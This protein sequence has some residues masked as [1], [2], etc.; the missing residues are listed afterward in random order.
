MNKIKKFIT[1]MHVRLAIIALIAVIGFVMLS[2]PSPT[3]DDNEDPGEDQG[4]KAGASVSVPVLASKTHNSITI[5]PSAFI[6][7]NPGEQTIEYAINGV[8]S[9]PEAGWQGGLKFSGLG[10]NMKYWIF[11]RSKSNVTHNAGKASTGLSVTTGS[12]KEAGAV[13]SIPVLALKTANSITIKAVAAPGN[14]Q[15]VE[16]AKNGT[17][18]APPTGWQD[19]LTFSGLSPST[20]YWIFARSKSNAAYN[21]GKA[22]AGLSV[23]TEPDINPLDTTPPVLSGG[24]INRTSNT[25]ALITFTT[26]EA[27]TA[28]YSQLT[29]GSPAPSSEAVKLA[30][31]IGAVIAGTNIEPVTLEAGVRD[32][33]VVVEDAAGN[34]SSPLKIEAPAYVVMTYNIGDI[35]PGGGIIFYVNPSGFTVEG[36]SGA[37]GAFESYT[38]HYLEAAPS[39]FSTSAQWGAYGTLISGITTFTSSTDPLANKIGNG[40]KDTLTIVAHLGTSETNRAAQLAA[41]ATFGGK[42]DWFLPSLGELNLLYVQKSLTGITTGYFWSSSQSAIYYAWLQDFSNGNRYVGTNDLTF[43]VRSIRAF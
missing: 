35:G 29:S 42:N 6:D 28:Y 36:Y 34:K 43:T 26:D 22:S 1:N 10:S 8:N 25:A 11:A 21:T 9:V 5:K 19:G 14:G 12:S 30:N 31:T 13:V 16:Y 27:G 24:S 2:C 23:T 37:E 41:A 7:G 33:Y 3:G 38:A 4:K 40:R 18:S 17:N 32:V 15:T 39:N 20:T